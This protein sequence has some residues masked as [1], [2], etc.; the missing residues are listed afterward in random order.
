[1]TGLSL[2]QQPCIEGYQSCI[3]NTTTHSLPSLSPASRPIDNVE[4]ALEQSLDNTENIKKITTCEELVTAETYNTN[5][6]S[7]RASLESH[8][9][10][11]SSSST[12]DASSSDAVLEADGENIREKNPGTGRKQGKAKPHQE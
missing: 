2:K 1:M 8:A 4:G 3:S 9:T 6:S 5:E 7:A 12:Y 10:P 11:L